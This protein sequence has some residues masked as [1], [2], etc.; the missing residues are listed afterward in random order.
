MGLFYTNI[1]LTGPAQEQVVTYLRAQQR[2]AYTSPTINGITVVYDRECES[3]DQTIL[4]TVTAG[5]SHALHCP[6]LWALLH[7]DDVFMYALYE[8]GTRVDAYNSEPGYFGWDSEDPPI[9]GAEYYWNG[10]PG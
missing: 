10:K 8:H 4:N 9:P 1:T 2:T 7:D 5:L 3:Q 6:A